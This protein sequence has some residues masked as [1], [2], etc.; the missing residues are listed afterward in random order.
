MDTQLRF[1]S[2][3]DAALLLALSV[4]A[5]AASVRV[6]S[7]PQDPARAV[8]VIYAPWTSAEAAL[9]NATGAGGRFVRFGGM[10]FVAVAIPDDE[11]YASRAYAAGAW[12]ILDP[13]FLAACMPFQSRLRVHDQS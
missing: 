10:S 6:A 2:A 1:R 5:L 7:V 4:G 8:A 11:H 13:Q 12:F 9:R 3:I